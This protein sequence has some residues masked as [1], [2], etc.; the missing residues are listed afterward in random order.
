VAN[1]DDPSMKVKVRVVHTEDIN[2]F[3]T[4]GGNIYVF[5]GLIKSA[6]NESMLAGVLAHE[7]AHAVAHHVTEGATRQ[8][9]T[10]MG[11]QIGSAV[12]AAVLGL[13]GGAAD[14]LAQGPGMAA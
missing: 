9:K 7:F 11:A 5:T 3:C 14:A 2:A 6:Q 4:L 10:Q 1:S 13:G 12:A 8:A